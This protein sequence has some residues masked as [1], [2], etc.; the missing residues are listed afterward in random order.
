MGV[1]R[2]GG[3]RII[4]NKVLGG[5]YVVRGPHNTPISGRFDSKYDAEQWLQRHKR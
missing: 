4:H 3:V 1:L 5:W 2:S